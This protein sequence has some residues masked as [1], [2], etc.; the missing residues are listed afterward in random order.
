MNS[1]PAILHPNSGL[2]RARG[3]WRMDYQTD[4][5]RRYRSTG[6]TDLAAARKI[7][8]AFYAELDA[9]GVFS[10]RATITCTVGNHG[11]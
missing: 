10:R 2:V 8:D 6:T 1:H 9:A 11:S 5:V 3:I 7:R 4:G